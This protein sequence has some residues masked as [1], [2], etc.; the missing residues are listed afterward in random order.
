MYV[1]DYIGNN[2]FNVTK[3]LDGVGIS[4]RYR[5]SIRGSF[6]QPVVYLDDN[7]ILNLDL[8]TPMRMEELDEIYLSSTAIVSS[9]N[10]NAGIIKLYSKSPEYSKALSKTKP[11][12]ITGGYKRATPFINS[13]YLSKTSKGF[14]NFGLIHWIPTVLTDDNG[15]FKFQISNDGPKTIQLRIE[16]IT[17]D[18]KI[19][20]E[21]K[22][23]TIE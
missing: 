20:S 15:N 23:V 21:V 4:G 3:N 5:T 18:G 22:E 10:N 19:I 6:T 13:D 14:E 2:G 12:I 8:L 9:M 17:N 1:L 16:G 11:F 7:R